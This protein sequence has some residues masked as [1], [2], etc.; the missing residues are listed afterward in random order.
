M[1]VAISQKHLSISHR[2]AGEI[3]GLS[4]KFN[5]G[6]YSKIENID[7]LLANR[8][9]SVEKKKRLLVGKLHRLAAK[10]FA[11][12]KEKISKKTLESLGARL[13]CMREITIKLRSLN[14]YLETT[15]LADLDFLKIKMP[16]QGRRL[17]GKS[18]IKGEL[19]ALEYTAYKLIGEVVTLDRRLLAEYTKKERKVIVREKAD[20]RDLGQI[21]AKE[22]EALEHL[23]AKLPPPR[24]L[25]M[26]M[27]KEPI[28]THWISRVLALLS[29]IEHLY[30]K[31][32]E[33]FRK[34]KNNKSAKARIC[35]KIIQL[36]RERSKL[37][38]IMD[39]KAAS[40]KKL[41]S[42]AE[43]RQEV[44]NLTTTITL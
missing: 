21:L 3:N 15:F 1:R 28:F 12:D 23:E 22:T 7:G 10:T 19:E 41:K 44:R 26:S 8:N 5:A 39:E 4:R 17:S 33:I 6:D 25:Q 32:A 27:M 24:H 16:L 35:K 30:G 2:L 11:V 14:N 38:D 18:A 42:D 36:A 20:V 43:F 37:L 31:E 34:L 9:I 40:M 29:Y 13:A